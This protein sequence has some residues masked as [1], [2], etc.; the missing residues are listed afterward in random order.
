V[1]L[2]GAQFQADADETLLAQKFPDALAQA[3]AF[4]VRELGDEG[5]PVA[6]GLPFGVTER[7]RVPCAGPQAAQKGV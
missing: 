6:Q 5:D 7:T 3:I 2:P 4:G 1:L